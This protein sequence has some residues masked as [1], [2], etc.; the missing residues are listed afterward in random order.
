MKKIGYIFV[1][2]ALLIGFGCKVK[3]TTTPENP[4]SLADEIEKPACSSYVTGRSYTDSVSDPFQIA[5]ASIEGKNL[6]VT[7]QYGGGCGDVEFNLVWDGSKSAGLPTRIPMRLHLRDRDYCKAYV[8]KELC[9]DIS[10]ANGGY[11]FQLELEG[12][13]DTLNFSTQ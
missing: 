2:Q 6:L 10:G 12:S 13:A 9:F 1:L 5:K 7:V 8:T 4:V 3:Q 11:D